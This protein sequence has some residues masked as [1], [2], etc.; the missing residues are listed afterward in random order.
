MLI[1]DL[2][3]GDIW[4]ATKLYTLQ[5]QQWLLR[6]FWLTEQ[7]LHKGARQLNYVL[8]AAV[9]LTALYYL[10]LAPSQAFRGKAYLTLFVAL[11][12]VFAIVAWLKALTNVSCP[13][14]LSLFGGS[15]PYLHLLQTKASFLP[16]QKCFP[17]GHA[18]VGYAWVALYYFFSRTH[19][20]Y[21]WFGLA[22]G[23]TAGV[24]LGLTQQLRGAHFLSHDLTTLCISFCT[25]KYCFALFDALVKQKSP[26][27]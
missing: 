11:L 20:D 18:S 7:V 25:A 23:L 5:G 24:I 1:L 2:G 15:E 26:R 22:L 3:G 21:R 16:R 19:P 10:C 4:L 13:W 14:H 8:V 17:A 27:P 12:S 9:L 6:D